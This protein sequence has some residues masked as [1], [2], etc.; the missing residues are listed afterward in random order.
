M[1]WWDKSSDLDWSEALDRTRSH[2][3]TLESLNTLPSYLCTFRSFIN[4]Q[5]N[6]IDTLASTIFYSG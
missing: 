2:L 4:N 6:G 1:S 3:L 5:T